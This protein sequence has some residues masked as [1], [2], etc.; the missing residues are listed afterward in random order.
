MEATTIVW[1]GRATCRQLKITSKH[2][3]WLPLCNFTGEEIRPSSVHVDLH[4][5]FAYDRTEK[6]TPALCSSSK[7]CFVSFVRRYEMRQRQSC[8]T[9]T[10][11][12]RDEGVNMGYSV[13]S[14]PLCGGLSDS[15]GVTWGVMP[16]QHSCF[17]GSLPC[18]CEDR[19]QWLFC[20]DT[21]REG[22]KQRT[23]WHEEHLRAQPWSG[24]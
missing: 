12:L 5:T 24:R 20:Q 21:N 2:S 17:T 6:E 15:G 4:V 9:F 13:I 22:Q 19:V 14:L 23:A 16:P 8:A 1:E 18:R 3:T 7:L 10:W 11:F